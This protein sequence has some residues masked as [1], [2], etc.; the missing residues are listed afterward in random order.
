MGH[1]PMGL[2]DRR[3]VGR[4]PARVVVGAQQRG[5]CFGEFRCAASPCLTADGAGADRLIRAVTGPVRIR[6]VRQIAP[7][8]VVR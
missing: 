2:G 8:G 6:L 3:L 4:E 5:K 1:P 7:S